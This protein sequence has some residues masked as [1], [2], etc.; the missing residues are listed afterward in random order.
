MYT[1]IRF[2]A[3]ELAHIQVEK[4][5]IKS[6]PCGFDSSKYT[7][8]KSSQRLDLKKIRVAVAKSAN[9]DSDICGICAGALYSH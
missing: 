9:A 3:V 2:E 4:G 8:E 5:G 7:M 1:L 6:F